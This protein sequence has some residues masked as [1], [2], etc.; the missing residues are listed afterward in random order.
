MQ[1]RSRSYAEITG[2]VAKGDECWALAEGSN[3]D[4]GF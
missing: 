2:G 3:G 1:S 4:I